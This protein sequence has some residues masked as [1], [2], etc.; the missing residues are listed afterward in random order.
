MNIRDYINATYSVLQA[1]TG[2]SDTLTRLKRNLKNRGLEKYYP[3]ILRGLLQKMEVRLKSSDTQVILARPEDESL[4]KTR[5]TEALARGETYHIHIDTSIIGG[6]I[7]KEKDTWIDQS[8]K[9]TLLQAYH[10]VT[11]RV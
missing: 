11:D 8:Y 1:E 6:F 4:Y 7:I 5:V 9:N 10:R 2:V 3:R